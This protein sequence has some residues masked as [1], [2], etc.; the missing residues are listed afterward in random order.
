[1]A[2]KGK[3]LIFSGGMTLCATEGA[4]ADGTILPGMSVTHTAT[5]LAK[6]AEASTVFGSPHLFADYDMLR[7]KTVDDL[8]AAGANV[9]ARELTQ[10][11]TA[12]LLVAAGTNSTK[13]GIALASNGDGT[14]KIA[15]TDGTDYILAYTD[16]ILNSV[17]VS[18]MRV[19]GA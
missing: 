2:D 17:G 9:I 12:N 15:A 3:R 6:N 18:L 11:D 4:A 14:L 16:E 7:A 13:R 19:K 10:G 8:Y 1:M 5:T